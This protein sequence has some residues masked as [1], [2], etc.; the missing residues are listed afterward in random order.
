MHSNLVKLTLLVS[1]LFLLGQ[2]G[3]QLPWGDTF[4]QQWIDSHTRDNGFAGVVNYF[5]ISVCLMS[6]G[7]PRQLVAFMGGYAFGVVQ[8]CLYSTLAAA[9]SCIVVV[10]FA[11]YFA[12]S[13]IQ[14]RLKEKMTKLNG[15]LKQDVL[16]K[17]IVVRLMPVGNNLATNL[18]AGVTQVRVLPF[19]TGSTI[20]YLPQMIIFSLM[21]KGVLVNSGANLIASILLF[22]LASLLGAYILK[23][24]RTQ[25]TGKPDHLNET[26]VNDSALH[27]NEYER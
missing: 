2:F 7:L 4:S 26:K 12:R 9:T 15:F 6:F 11:R 3:E 14:I 1:L 10:F 13:F 24:Y 19:V 27:T 8:G 23:K 17:S 25:I 22:L 16:V 20:G 21:G 5:C 18:I